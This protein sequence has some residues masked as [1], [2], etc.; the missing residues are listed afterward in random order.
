MAVIDTLPAVKVSVRLRTS[1]RDADEY[2]DP[3]GYQLRD[4]YFEDFERCSRNYIE[5][6]NGVEFAVHINIMDDMSLDPWIYGDCG[7]MFFLFIDGQFMG[8][9][10]CHS[11]DFFHH[12]ADASTQEFRRACDLGTIEV[13]EPRYDTFDIPEEALK[14][15]PISHGTSFAPPY[16]APLR[17]PRREQRAAFERIRSG[18]LLATYTFKYRDLNALRI[19]EI[20]PRTPSP[21]STSPQKSVRFEEPDLPRFEELHQ[22]EIERLARDRLRQLR[23]QKLCGSSKKRSYDDYCDLT[24][25]Y[26]PPARPY[27]IIKMGTGQEAI[28]LTNDF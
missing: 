20:V 3:Y 10:F 22:D 23:D 7:L 24:Q 8:K 14:G 5:S 11:D 2:P 1:F 15:R 28:D 18:P 21:E 16:E 9:R 4:R 19:E 6:Q 27:K 26:S 25:D 17:P 12:D 13:K